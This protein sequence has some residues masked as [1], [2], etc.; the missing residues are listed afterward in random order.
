M[1]INIIS[2]C[3]FWCHYSYILL[4]NLLDVHFQVGVSSLHE[5]IVSHIYQWLMVRINILWGLI[6]LTHHLTNRADCTAACCAAISTCTSSN[7][8]LLSHFLPHQKGR[9]EAKDSTTTNII[10]KT[11]VLILKFFKPQFFCKHQVANWCTAAD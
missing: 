3:V 11:Q 2:W 1:K 6:N 4:Q 7:A 5:S 9:N 8:V 10:E